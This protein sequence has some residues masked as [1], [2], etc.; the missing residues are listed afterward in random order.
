MANFALV[1][2]ILAALLF[3]FLLAKV[4]VLVARATAVLDKIGR[5]VDAEMV[6]AV[7]AWGEA[8]RGVQ[9]AVGKLD[10]GLESLSG[11]LAR[12]DRATQRLEPEALTLSVLQPAL[13]KVGSWLGGVRRG[14]SGVTGHREKTVGEGVETEVG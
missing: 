9:N 3:I 2:A 11:I 5:L 8:A 1:L 13:A 14:L 7:G 10:Q 12:L 4:Y 6:E